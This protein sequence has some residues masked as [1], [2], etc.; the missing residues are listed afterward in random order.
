MLIVYACSPTSAYRIR[1]FLFD[2]VPDPNEV[3]VVNIDSTNN[4]IDSTENNIRLT[5][6]DFYKHPPYAKKECSSCH[7]RGAMGKPKL[8]LPELCYQCHEPIERQYPALHGPVSSGQCTMCHSPHQSKFENLLVIEGRNLCLNCHEEES[9]TGKGI[10]LNITEESCT[11]CHNPHGG[12]DK[13]ILQ[14]E[15]CFNCHENKKPVNEYQFVHGPV[16]AGECNL[17]H[18]NHDSS[19]ENLLIIQGNNLCLNCHKT[20]DII[21]SEPHLANKKQMCTRCHDPH[22]SNNQYL[23]LNLKKD[24]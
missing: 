23:T 7:D 17:C 8:D 11:K 16:A 10:H 21:K 4:S 24:S 3:I 5:K 9:I 19:S 1:S 12:H 20:S 13:F 6:P 22:L 2:G 18:S 15:T 14:K